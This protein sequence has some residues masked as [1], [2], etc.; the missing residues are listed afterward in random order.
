ML[1]ICQTCPLDETQVKHYVDDEVDLPLPCQEDRM[2]DS[3]IIN[4]TKLDHL[5]KRF[6]TYF[7]PEFLVV[8]SG[9][10]CQSTLSDTVMVS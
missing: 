1:W 9:R 7:N 3:P 10:I 5:V 2:S 6:T 8:F 4:D